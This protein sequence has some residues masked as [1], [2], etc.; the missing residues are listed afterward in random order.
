MTMLLSNMMGL[1]AADTHWFQFRVIDRAAEA[2]D[3]WRGDFWGINFALEDY[4][5]R[6][7][8]AHG[9]E[10]G[11]L[12][13]LINQT[14]DALRQQD[15]Q[16]PFAVSDGSDH[17]YIEDL[18]NRAST[19]IEHRVNLQKYFVFH[20]LVEAVR[21]YDF[22]PTANKNMTYYFEPT[23]TPQN[24][25]FGKLWVL[26][27]DTDATWGPTWNEGKDV[28]YDALFENN[29]AAY[30]NALINPQY[31]NTLR[32]LRDLI[33]QPDQLRGMMEEL[34]SKILPLEAADRARWQGA[35]ADAGNY[36]GLG[37]AGATSL[38]N[39]RRGHAQL[40]FQRRQLARRHGGPR[41]A[42]RVSRRLADRLG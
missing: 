24:D 8:D 31:Y 27:W 3:Q 39:A 17:D 29:N 34:V 2:P 23:Y 26:L 16:A 6:F 25:N 35:P 1:P 38:T 36:N 7:L 13:K 22:W 14:N 9:L 20:A 15:Y 12:Y 32:E 21:H 40:R 41:W 42:R 4:D 28:V 18:L 19:D 11:N 10:A 33:W 5:K 37:G 30:R